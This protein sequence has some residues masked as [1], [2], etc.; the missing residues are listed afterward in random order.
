[1]DGNHTLPRRHQP[2]TTT[3]IAVTN[4]L[5]NCTAYYL[6]GY[7][8]L[9]LAGVWA[10]MVNKRKRF[11]KG[12][13]FMSV[14]ASNATQR[15]AK[16]AGM[17]SVMIL[18][19]RILGFIRENISGRFFDRFE[20][21]AYIAA[22]I[23][24]DTMYYLLVG[25]A[26]AAAFIPIFTEYL[27]R[28][29]EEEGWKV[30]STFINIT[31]L[32]LAAFT[33]F[34]MGFARWLAPLE[35]PNFSPAKTRLLVELTR[36]MFPAVCFTALAGMMGGV[37]NSYH[38]FFIPSLGSVIYNIVIIAGAVI[39]GPRIGIK[40]MAVGV[41]LGALTNFLFQ[42]SGVRK[43]CGHHYRFGYIDLKNPGFHRMLW[44]M[45]PALIGL[46][47]TQANLVVTNMM[48]S[49]LPEGS[50]TALRFANRLIL[51][52]IGIFASGIA[53]AFF[54]LLSSL[55]AQDK[56]DSFKDTLTL[57][58][59]SIFFLMIPAA[60]GL[61]VLRVP[62]VKLL[63]EGQ[64]FTSHDTQMTAYALFF[65]SLALF[66]HAALLMLP[67]AFYAL[68]DT[69][70]PVVVSVIAVTSSIV[71]NWLFLKFTNLGVGGFALSF[72]L[73]G[74]INM[75]LLMVI[76]KR[77]IGDIRGRSLATSFAK[78]LVA[79]L[80]MGGAIILVNGLLAPVFN[81]LQGHLAAAAMIGVGMTIGVG[82]FFGMAVALK[83]EELGTVLRRFK[84][85]K[86]N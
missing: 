83:M 57:S 86:V 1:M 85:S 68:K 25:G 48:A 70:T 49:S 3:G 50:I 56:I 5:I 51:L 22:F 20:T 38:Y 74:L 80:V 55:V 29:K 35:A 60:V 14:M 27:A 34:G 15:A 31:I 4:L 82:V 28:D 54:P 40:G 64:K 42:A 41:V 78:T 18:I 33:I 26:L 69:R 24:P 36:V 67:R 43:H 61:I 8:R 75:L 65:Y 23:I 6:C 73:M 76:L 10:L 52:P 62:L 45:L 53:V 84:H 71:M 11:L 72:S 12:V 59:R 17:I 21:D 44:L 37:L 13:S 39:L 19:S 16:A 58:L 32:L 77:K 66:A 47:A 7:F 79:S 81:R 9:F 63:F 46:S 30:A 2:E